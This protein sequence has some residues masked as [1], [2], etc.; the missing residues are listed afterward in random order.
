MGRKCSSV[1]RA[2]CSVLRAWGSTSSTA[3][4]KKKKQKKKKNKK[5][6][7]K[8]KGKE[9]KLTFQDLKTD[10]IRV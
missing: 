10:T 3:K 6:K 5:R 8:E 1:G 7:R 2:L 4:K 9:K